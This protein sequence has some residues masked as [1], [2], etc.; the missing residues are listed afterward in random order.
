MGCHAAWA[1]TSHTA[2]SAY[3]RCTA[4]AVAHRVPHTPSRERDPWRDRVRG[5]GS[6]AAGRRRR[7][8]HH[9]TSFC[10]VL[11]S[12]HGAAQRKNERKKMSVEKDRIKLKGYLC[13]TQLVLLFLDDLRG[14][15]P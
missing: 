3:N 6:A 12:D 10:Y 15:V 14:L 8:A 5:R 11:I 9:V 7:L 13:T 4:L 1:C 2:T